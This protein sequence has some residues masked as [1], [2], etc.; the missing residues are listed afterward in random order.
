MWQ[1]LFL[2]RHQVNNALIM[3]YVNKNIMFPTN[4]LFFIKILEKH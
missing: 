4:I 3:L 2:T 1:T